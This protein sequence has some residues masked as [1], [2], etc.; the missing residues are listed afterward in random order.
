MAK[1]KSKKKKK[2]KIKWKN[3]FKALF[4]LLF[5]V[6]LVYVAI[7]LC[8]WHADYSSMKKALEK[9][10][11]NNFIENTVDDATTMVINSPSNLS[12]FDPYWNYVKLGLINCDFTEAKKINPDISGWIELKGTD[13]D[14]PVMNKDY[15]K[16]HSLLKDENEYGWLYSLSDATNYESPTII[17]GNKNLFGGLL[18]DLKKLSQDKW[19]QNSDNYIVRYTTEYYTGLY[20]IFSIYKTKNFTEP[21]SDVAVYNEL[22]SKSMIDFNTTLT[23]SDKIITLTT[24]NDGEKIVV[25]AKLL[26][27][28]LLQ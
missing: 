5:F 24:N 15:Y 20:Q 2:Y 17:Y 4:A 21:Q 6:L 10:E 11:N 28:R 13:I 19:Q 27:V 8:G 7:F 25:H 18:S 14:Y 22:Y 1:G 26:K 3:W 23:S 12:N 9:I 16:N